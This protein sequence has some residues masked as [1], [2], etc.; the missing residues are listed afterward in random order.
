MKRIHFNL[1]QH[2]PHF[3]WNSPSYYKPQPLIQL[4]G[5]IVPLVLHVGHLRRPE[6]GKARLLK[7]TV[8][9]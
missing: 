6:G 3:P 9:T 5:T 1:L 2:H 7:R 4:R 8:G